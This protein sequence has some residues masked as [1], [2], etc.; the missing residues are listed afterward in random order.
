MFIAR[1]P[2]RGKAPLGAACRRL[3]VPQGPGIPLL[4]ELPRPFPDAKVRSR[5]PAP[6]AHRSAAFRLQNILLERS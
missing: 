5:A 1:L 2:P 4:K 3:P 6:P